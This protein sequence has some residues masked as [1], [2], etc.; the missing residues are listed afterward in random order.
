MSS[1]LMEKYR[2]ANDLCDRMSLRRFRRRNTYK[3]R[4]FWAL[5]SVKS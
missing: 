2:N 4:E 1:L 3:E 5:G